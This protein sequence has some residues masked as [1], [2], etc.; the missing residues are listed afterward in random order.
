MAIFVTLL[1]EYLEFKNNGIVID[2]KVKDI[3]RSP[4]SNVSYDYSVVINYHDSLYYSLLLSDQ[5]LS[6]GESVKVNF[7]PSKPEK[8]KLISESLLFKP[9]TSLFVVLFF[10]FVLIISF[11]NPQF[12]FDHTGGDVFP[13]D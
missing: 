2:A 6:K 11:V 4:G 13:G 1:I 9:A 8:I 7:L 3:K 10:F 5:D 12:I